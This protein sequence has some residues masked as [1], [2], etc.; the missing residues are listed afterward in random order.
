VAVEQ[1][2][3]GKWTVILLLIHRPSFDF[4]QTMVGPFDFLQDLLC[5]WISFALCASTRKIRSFDVLTKAQQ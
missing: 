4:K 1:P 2:E 3:M 5:V